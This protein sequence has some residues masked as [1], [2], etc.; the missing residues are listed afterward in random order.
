[1]VRL[2]LDVNEQQTRVLMEALELYTRLGTGDTDAVLTHPA[3][4]EMKPARLNHAK[5]ALY[6]CKLAAFPQLKEAGDA[7]GIRSEEVDSQSR[8][9]YDILQ[10][11]KH[12]M[13]LASPNPR[14]SVWYHAP[15]RASHQPL[16]SCRVTTATR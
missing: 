6:S 10:V 12:E 11:M 7:L 9:A 4:Q 13:V 5:Q 16:P 2:S 3:F 8:E 14:Q 1:M 15:I